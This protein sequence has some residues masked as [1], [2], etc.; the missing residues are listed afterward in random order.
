MGSISLHVVCISA[1][2]QFS[3]LGC[4]IALSNC[5]V[6][7]TKWE[8]CISFYI[9]LSFSDRTPVTSTASSAWNLKR[10]ADRLKTYEMWSV[11]FM[12]PHRLAAAGF[13]SINQ[14][15]VVRC[16][17]CGVEVGRWEEGDEPF[18][19]HQRW[20][21]SCGFV[22]GMQVGNIPISEDGLAEGPSSQE[23]SGGCDVCGPH[24]EIRP[25]SGPE[26][27]ANSSCLNRNLLTRQELQRPGIHQSRG[28]LQ[29]SYNTYDARLRSY[30]GWPCSL[31]QKP[32]KLV[33]ITQVSGMAWAM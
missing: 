7:L 6:D 25:N 15:D 13:Y 20:A 12:D 11:P 16:A 30:E 9:S 2:F 26:R 28:P 4:D 3:I 19:D 8:I 17:F 33:S 1:I 21:P 14:G 31:G 27:A 29:P 23:V 32:D 18:K 22:R 24:M 5:S 10:E